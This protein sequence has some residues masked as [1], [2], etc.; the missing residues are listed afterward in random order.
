ML[1]TAIFVDN[2]TRVVLLYESI[3]KDSRFTNMLID[4]NVIVRSG[5][6]LLAPCHIK[7]LIS[8]QH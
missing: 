3:G 6:L 8:T 1:E 5:S 2:Q 7:V 4:L